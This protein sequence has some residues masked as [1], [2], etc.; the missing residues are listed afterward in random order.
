MYF[1]KHIQVGTYSKFKKIQTFKNR[2]LLILYSLLLNYLQVHNYVT[3][4][5]ILDLSK[6]KKYLLLK[7]LYAAAKLSV[8]KITFRNL[9]GK[10][11][12]MRRKLKSFH[13]ISTAK[14][15]KHTRTNRENLQFDKVRLA[16]KKT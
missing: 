16:K 7:K 4:Y 9:I 5:I 8:A 13:L 3:M 1:I 2:Y 12:L 6:I 10:K 14:L 15:I 11:N